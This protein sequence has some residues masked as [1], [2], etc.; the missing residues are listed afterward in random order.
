MAKAAPKQK[1][2]TD[3]QLK[4]VHYYLQTLNGTKAAVKAGYSNASAKVEGSRLL[5]KANVREAIK[6][7]M[8]E[9]LAEHKLT[10]KGRIIK[11][12]IDI[13]FG[14]KSSNSDRIKALDAL[15]KY[16]NLWAESGNTTINNYNINPVLLSEGQ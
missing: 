8:D 5:T 14:K 10:L 3:R 15:A 6:K 4:F 11:G 13:A 1:P 2:Q 12:Y 9:T 16:E 7:V